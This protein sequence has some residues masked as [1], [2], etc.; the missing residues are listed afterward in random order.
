MN[1]ELGLTVL[2]E[3]SNQSCMSSGEGRLRP[4]ENHRVQSKALFGRDKGHEPEEWF[5][6]SL[7][8]AQ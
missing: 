2:S 1:L 3:F 6:Y 5:R 7:G 8:C 4:K